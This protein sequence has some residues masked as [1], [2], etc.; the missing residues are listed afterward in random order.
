MARRMKMV[1]SG[2]VQGVGFRAATRRVADQLGIQGT[3]RNIAGCV[4]I[5]AEGT[6]SDLAR[7]EDWA[8]HGP[9]GARV[10]TVEVSHSNASGEFSG[11][12]VA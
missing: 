2:K 12:L 5:I 11:F 9:P 10:D 7:L 4:E 3:V 1:V 6:E 8:R